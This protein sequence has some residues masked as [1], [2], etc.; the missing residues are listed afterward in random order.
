MLI[1]DG[2]SPPTL[3]EADL[4]IV[5]NEACANVYGGSILPSMVCA[6]YRR[7]GVDTCQVRRATG[8]LVKARVVHVD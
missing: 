2:P 6:G 4:P 3:Y 1:S 8:R 7:G 5:T